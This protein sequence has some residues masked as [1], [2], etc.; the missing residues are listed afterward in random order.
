MNLLP[1]HRRLLALAAVT[2][3]LVLLASCGRVPGQFEILNDQL[4]LA[5]GSG[6][7]I[8]VNPNMYRGQ[9][10]L[11]LS[12]VRADFPTAYYVFPLL[13]NNLPASTSGSLDPNEIQLSGFNIDVA[14]LGNTQPQ[15]VLDAFSSVPSYDVHYQVPWSGGIGSGGGQ[16]SAF[17]AAFPVPL[18]EALLASGAIASG[19]SLDV[20]LTVQAI[21]TTNSGQDMTSDPFH[22]PVQV[23][24]GCLVAN[25]GPCPFAMPPPNPGNACNPAQ[26][27]PV[28]CCT[29]NGSL[30]CPALVATQ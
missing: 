29:S 23:C 2:A 17:A 6:C 25:V 3:P 1:S 19:P 12:I 27:D 18:A 8:P 16:L 4:P 30:I 14:P 26:D 10:I 21:G 15:A 24:D 5:A 13:E 22:F 11:D 7:S 20:D 28:D 9:G